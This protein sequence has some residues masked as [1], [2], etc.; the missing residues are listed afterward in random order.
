M[1]NHISFRALRNLAAAALSLFFFMI[2]GGGLRAEPESRVFELRTYYT[3]PGKLEA[4]Q[5]RFRDHTV[6][7][8][9][10]HG[11]TN[12]AYW[13]PQ[14][15]EEQILVYLMAY[16]SREKRDEMWKAFQADSEWKAAYAASTEEGKLV[17]RVDSVFLK[18]TDYSP[19]LDIE[20]QNPARLF[21][22]RRYTANPEKLPKLD[23]RFRD[24]TI[25]L[26]TAHGMTNVIYFHLA[27]GEEGAG[28]TLVYLLAHR[29]NRARDA[30]FDAFRQDP[31]WQSARKASEVGG[32]LLIKRGV[33]SLL[34]NPVDFSPMR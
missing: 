9:E 27:A 14:A 2:V 8:F 5:A 33:Q 32:S 18:A 20:A 4:L 24:H 1:M 13:V 3:H 17:K 12:V 26:F 22:L 6:K 10:K 29:D 16:P 34:L 23:A 28:N 31:D 30:S 11:M 25:R 7:L 21:E 19:V 15:N